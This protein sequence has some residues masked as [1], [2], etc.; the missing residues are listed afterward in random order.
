MS[1]REKYSYDEIKFKKENTLMIEGLENKFIDEKMILSP[2]YKKIKVDKNLKPY[3]FFPLGDVR[4]E[5]YCKECGQRRIYSFEDSHIALNSIMSGFAPSSMSSSS[6]E[7]NK[8]ELEEE[9][10][11]LDYFTLQAQAD[12][13]HNMIIVFKKIDNET[14]MK[15]GQFPSIYDL[16]EEINNKPFIKLLGKEYSDYYKKA[17]SLYSFDT[18]IGALIYLRRIFEKILLDTFN[19]NI[20]NLDKSF[21]EFKLMRMEEKIQYLKDYL[22]SLIFEQ[23]FNKMYTKI[24]DGVHNLTEEECYK[25]FT[26]LKAGIE[27]IL[28]E[29]LEKESRNKRLK[30]LS[31]ELQN[32]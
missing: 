13:K 1:V 5:C 26:I 21:E 23:G 20:S 19:D 6:F 3:E 29:K 9:L 14:I 8:T 10:E 25:I 12:C 15:V 31:K 7:S 18:Y 2:L 16:N 11:N 28:I 24:S 32:A 22:P 30:E 27:E 17:C 4:V